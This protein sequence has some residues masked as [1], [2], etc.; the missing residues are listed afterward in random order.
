M[1]PELRMLTLA[2]ISWTSV[3][4]LTGW[5]MYA[6]VMLIASLCFVSADTWARMLRIQ[7]A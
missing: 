3:A 5:G 7:I 6:L 1:P 2:I 4:I